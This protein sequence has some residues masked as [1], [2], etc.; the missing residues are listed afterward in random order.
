MNIFIAVLLALVALFLLTW[1]GI[2]LFAQREALLSK[3]PLP[4]TPLD[5]GVP[6]EDLVIRIGGRRLQAWWVRAPATNDTKKAVL[7]YH[8]N[9]ETIPEW[10][11]VMRSLWEHGISSFVF[12]YSGF[13]RSTGWRTF[14]S[15]RQD[16]IA[17]RR[18]FDEKAAGLEKY[19][20]GLSLGS[21]VL[22]ESA[23]ALTQG[24]AGLFLVAAFSSLGDAARNMHIVPTPLTYLAPRNYDNADHI[25]RV[26]VPVL[27]V[28]STEDELFPTAMAEKLFAAANDPKRLVMVHG[29]KHGDIVE[30]NFAGYLAPILE[31]LKP[32][33]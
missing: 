5:Q 12:D 27:I 16:A 9:T 6:F 1:G 19:V 3:G 30:Q 14:G 24:T 13:G 31:S 33:P 22:L 18:L 23:S 25:R 26:H 28:H 21:G 15:L 32:R 10:I 7:I 29:L 20:L 2:Y 11:P 4:G 8:G 17:A